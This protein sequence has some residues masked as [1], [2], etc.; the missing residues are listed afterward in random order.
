MRE[1]GKKESAAKSNITKSDILGFFYRYPI[2]AIP[3]MEKKKIIGILLKDTLTARSSTISELNV[4]MKK[5]ISEH[6]I[7]VDTQKDYH[8][9]Q[10]LLQNFK[11]VKTIPALDQQGRLVATLSKSDLICLWEDHP[12]MRELEWKRLFDGFSYT[13]IITDEKGYIEYTNPAF[14]DIIIIGRGKKIHGK[15]ITDVLA[16][17]PLMQGTPVIGQLMVID[18]EDF[19]CDAMPMNHGGNGVVYLIRA[20]R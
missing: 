4:P 9:L 17:I 8:A 15:L 19:I 14:S 13:V 12:L 16:G 1:S 20:S 10:N 3:V 18:G 6:L 2:R 7:P 5:V 11:K